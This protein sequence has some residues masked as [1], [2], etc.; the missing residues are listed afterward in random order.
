MAVKFLTPTQVGTLYNE[1]E[2]A[3]FDDKTEDELIKA[4][5][6]E[7]VKARAA[8]KAPANGATA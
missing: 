4:K 8:D 1:G 6:A 7:A 3:S 2:I 5:V